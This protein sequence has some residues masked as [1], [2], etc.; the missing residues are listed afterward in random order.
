MASKAPFRFR[1]PS[2]Q[3]IHWFAAE[4][5]VEDLRDMNSKGSRCQE[6]F[7]RGVRALAAALKSW[8]IEKDVRVKKKNEECSQDFFQFC[9]FFPYRMAKEEASRSPNAS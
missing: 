9:T 3:T 4:R 2:F 7:I 6:Q 5:I 8:T 1:F